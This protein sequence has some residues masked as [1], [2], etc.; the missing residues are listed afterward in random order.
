MPIGGPQGER[1][2][3]PQ[4]MDRVLTGL[5]KEVRSEKV[6]DRNQIERRL[7]A[8]DWKIREDRRAWQ[9]A[10]EGAYLL[11]TNRP[12]T[13]PDKLWKSCI[14]L[15]E[16]EAPFDVLKSE[17]AVRP[18][19]STGVPYQDAR[20]RGVSRLRALGH[21]PPSSGKQKARPVSCPGLGDR[22][23]SA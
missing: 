14:R 3:D 11:H 6:K 17:L 2:S 9:Q 1:E 15:M 20:A 19:F 5:G 7:G 21:P 4:H 23:L 16:A 8:L 10:R 22:L 18:I 13:D 12:P